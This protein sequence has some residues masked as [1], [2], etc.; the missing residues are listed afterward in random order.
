MDD[1]VNHPAHYCDG[2]IET[3]D[4]LRAKL[5]REQ[6]LGFLRGNALKYLSRAG[7]KGNAAEDF[8]KAEWYMRKLAEE[9]EGMTKPEAG[10]QLPKDLPPRKPK[11]GYGPIK[12]ICPDCG[13][14]YETTWRAQKYCDECRAARKEEKQEKTWV[15][16]ISEEEL[17]KALGVKEVQANDKA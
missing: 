14:E 5:P 12:K 7:K 4:Y 10:E 3:I 13:K 17:K 9:S 11:A 8:A 2:G 1:P 15:K 6:F 16:P